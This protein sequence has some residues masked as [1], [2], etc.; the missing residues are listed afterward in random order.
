MCSRTWWVGV[1]NSW[2]HVRA[3]RESR[4]APYFTP[5]L[6]DTLLCCSRLGRPVHDHVDYLTFWH[7]N[8][9]AALLHFTGLQWFKKKHRKQ[10][11]ETIEM[12][13]QCLSLAHC[14]VYG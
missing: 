7:F 14:G 2:K 1:Y 3:H 6:M 8:A 12:V 5:R 10:N 4:R 11:S 9:T 13:F